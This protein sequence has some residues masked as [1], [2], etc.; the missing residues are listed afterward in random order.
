[1]MNILGNFKFMRKVE[2]TLKNGVKL[3]VF[4]IYEI[5]VRLKMFL[6]W[7]LFKKEK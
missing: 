2:S 6:D 4:F 3:F 1:M 5:L 7:Y